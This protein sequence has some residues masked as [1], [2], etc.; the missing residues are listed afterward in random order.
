MS[1]ESHNRPIV[2]WMKN[3]IEYFMPD[4]GRT[5][6]GEKG[7]RGDRRGKH[8]GH[9]W[10]FRDITNAREMGTQEQ[11]VMTA[12][13]IELNFWYTSWHKPTSM[14]SGRLCGL[15]LLAQ[16]RNLCLQQTEQ[17]SKPHQEKKTTSCQQLLLKRYGNAH[18]CNKPFIIYT[19]YKSSVDPL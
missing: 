13:E 3:S 9:L 8:S 11:L 12:I 15:Q 5:G 18:F 14:Q 7:G 19:V 1:Q 16:Q 6:R 2:L 4:A 17:K 10:Q